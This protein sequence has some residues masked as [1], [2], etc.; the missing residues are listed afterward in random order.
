[1]RK[2]LSF[3]IAAA[4][5]LTLSGCFRIVENHGQM[6]DDSALEKLR[7]GMTQD[8][9][10]SLLGHPVL[11]APFDPDT[12]TYIGLKQHHVTFFSPKIDDSLVLALKFDPTEKT[13]TAIH[14]YDARHQKIFDTSN[15][16]TPELIDK[17]P[18]LK[19]L[20]GT[21]GRFARKYDSKNKT[22][23]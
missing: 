14:A 18:F 2:S 15:K 4:T 20:L 1:M 12:W 10:A 3:F 16:I 23:Q 11:S 8:Q 6:V 21:F 13:L 22:T 17:R 7:V 19:R 9:V 5:L